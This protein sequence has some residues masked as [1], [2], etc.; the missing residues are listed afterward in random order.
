VA[1]VYYRFY[2]VGFPSPWVTNQKVAHGVEVKVCDAVYEV[3]YF[4]FY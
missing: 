2:C 1:V 3:V 4:V